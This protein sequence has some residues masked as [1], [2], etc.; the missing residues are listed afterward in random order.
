MVYN[1]G[2]ALRS[3]WFARWIEAEHG[4]FFLLLPIA[5]GSA[6][7]LYF[8]LP[9]EPPLWLGG[10][11]LT[12]PGVILAMCWRLPYVRF[13]AFLALAAA[14][15]FA[16][17]EWRTASLPAMVQIPSG[18]SA[19]SGFVLRI[20]AL[21]HGTRVLLRAPKINDGPTLSRTIQVKLKAGDTPPQP[22]TLIKC[23]ALLFAP[24]SPA[25]PGGWDQSRDY[26]FANIAAEGVALTNLWTIHAAPSDHFYDL[27]QMVRGKITQTLLSTLPLSTGSVAVTL[28]TGDE[29]IIPPNERQDFVLSGLAHILAVAGLHVGIVMGLFF[30]LTR[31][32]LSRI[33]WVALHWPCKPIA[34]VV[35][36]AAGGG[37]AL[38]TGAHLPILRSLDMACLA[39]LGVIM[40]RR[41]IS[42]RGLGVAAMAL[43]LAMPEMVL[44]ASFQMS[45][46]AVAALIAGYEAIH[47][48]WS[49]FH[50]MRRGIGKV[51]LVF[52]ELAFTSLLAGGASMAFAAY[53]F[54]QITPYW[55]PANLIAVPLTA[56]WI[57][58]LGLAGLVLI[59]FHLAW[60][61]FYPMGWGIGVIVWITQHIATWPDAQ[62]IVKLV[63]GCAILLYAA[64]LAW[65]CIWRSKV[66]LAGIGGIAFG[67]AVAIM[68]TP[69][70]ILVSANADLIAIHNNNKVFLISQHKI[71]RFTLEQWRYVWGNY[72]ETPA[73]CSADT[74]LIGRVL[75]ANVAV[76]DCQGA[77][78]LVSP[79]P[80]PGCRGVV[81]LDKTRATQDG[82][83]EAWVEPSGAVSWRSDKS[84]QGHRPWSGL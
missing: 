57:M 43:M 35:A 31:W 13:A 21:P 42:L 24:Q 44:S 16:R 27:L 49:K 65:L 6:I 56:L 62:I 68:A 1:Q 64:G 59:P 26:Y 75:Y 8:A 79:V 58:P 30:V 15:G 2:V 53:Q 51:L 83:L 61:C 50:L 47:P 22:G 12:L 76:T 81:A 38:L 5:M 7:L 34:A 71:G 14:L 48:L 4:H 41:V 25:Y 39:T 40:G 17:A 78:L 63:P 45:F 67:L 52:M 19:L 77:N 11:L 54:Q 3:G 9:V 10:M 20:E 60:L 70:T 37:Y 55:I 84:W 32:L 28:L 82:A 74:C 29:Q 69:P 36:L 33:A 80:Q 66:R 72:P 73:Q 46:S 23:D 18:V